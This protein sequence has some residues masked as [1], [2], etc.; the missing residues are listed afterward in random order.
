MRQR[1]PRASRSRFL[2]VIAAVSVTMLAASSPIHSAVRGSHVTRHTA[3][4]SLVAG[5]GVL[6]A[7]RFGKG[8]AE[9][10][11]GKIMI[12]RKDGSGSRILAKGWWSTVSPD[13]SRVAV[14]DSDVADNQATNWRLELFAS[15]GGTPAHVIALECGPSPTVEQA[16]HVE[17]DHVRDALGLAAAHHLAANVDAER[18]HDHQHNE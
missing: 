18:S 5:G 6:T 8:F 14:I 11:P 3:A 17:C 13:G 16:R 4:S 15:A 7:S 10:A 2:L 9:I 12:A 1:W